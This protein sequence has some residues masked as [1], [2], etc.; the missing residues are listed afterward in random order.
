[1]GLVPVST[2]AQY[3][4][5]PARRGIGLPPHPVRVREVEDKE[6]CLW[7]EYDNGESGEV[8]LSELVDEKPFHMWKTEKGLFQTVHIEGDTLVWDQNI[9]I[10]PET[11][12][13]AATGRSLEEVAPVKVID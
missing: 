9:D 2:D 4:W 12:Y 13:M 5:D 11:I 8:D 10:A 3:V 6:W 1:M 7:I